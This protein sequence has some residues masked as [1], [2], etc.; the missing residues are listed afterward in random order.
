[1]ALNSARVPRGE[2]LCAGAVLESHLLGIGRPFARN[3][4]SNFVKK[5]LNVPRR[6]KA[7]SMAVPRHPWVGF[8][9]LLGSP[10]GPKGTPKELKGT[11]KEPQG[12]QQQPKGTQKEPKGIQKEP[13]YITKL[14]T[15]RH[16]A[17]STNSRS[18]AKRRG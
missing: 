18:T 17:I 14:P 12:T 10:K 3:W 8:G 13:N 2:I 5:L 9:G 4:T 15:H 11:P 6:T 1:M 7:T 16:R